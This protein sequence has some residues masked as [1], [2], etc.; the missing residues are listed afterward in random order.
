MRQ[1]LDTKAM[2][3]GDYRLDVTVTGKGKPP[4]TISRE[5]KITDK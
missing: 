4:L 1:V 2:A 5:F 3:P